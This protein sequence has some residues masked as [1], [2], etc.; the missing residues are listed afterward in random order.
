MFNQS[1][2]D[3]FTEWLTNHNLQLKGKHPDQLSYP[4]ETKDLKY[5]AEWNGDPPAVERFNPHT[6]K[7]S[8]TPAY[9]VYENVSEGTPISPVF[10]HIKEVQRWVVEQ[11]GL[12]PVAAAEFC[13]LRWAP[14]AIFRLKAQ[15][16]HLG[17]QPFPAPAGK[18]QQTPPV[19]PALPSI[20]SGRK[21]IAQKNAKGK[22]RKT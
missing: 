18:Q 5:F 16:D 22:R 17:D 7:K 19:I 2:I 15:T 4:A 6:W 20:Q 3:A 14:T 8:D 13:E 10:N 9:Q 11:G 12:S 1:Y 21:M